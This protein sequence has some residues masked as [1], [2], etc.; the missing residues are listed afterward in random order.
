M[1][2]NVIFWAAIILI[3]FELL[4]IYTLSKSIQSLLKSDFFRKKME[5]S[6]K[7]KE[8]GK[9][10]K[11][12]AGTVATLLVLFAL[13]F[14]SFAQEAAT[15]ATSV[16]EVVEGTASDDTMKYTIYALLS[17]IVLLAGV[18]YYLKSLF[19]N[20]MRIDKTDEEIVVERSEANAKFV[21]VL[22]DAVD[23]EDEASIDLGHEYDGIR[24]LDNNLPPWWK[25][26]FYLTI[27]IGVIYLTH[28]HVLGTGDL[29]EEEYE[30]DMAQAELDIQAY[31][32]EQAM[33]VDENTVTMLLDEGAI[34]NG[35]SLFKNFCVACHGEN[36]EGRVGP[37]LTDEYWINGGSIKDIFKTIKYG[38]NNGMKSWKD[39]LNPVQMQQVASY[40]QS[41]IGTNPP[42]AKD[43]EGDKYTPEEAEE[44]EEKEGD[45]SAEE[46][47]QEESPEDKDQE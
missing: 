13:P 43:P 4:V 7:Q 21:K 40:I 31:L 29:Q 45:T 23:I 25:W 24:E 44:T 36:G 16:V 14:A 12:G 17:I 1:E 33:N 28:Y 3:C 38:A 30:K 10:D 2:T 34:N 6:N 22:T 41:I 42:N 46:N 26:G 39:E 27:F 37:N 15:E 47:A 8:E 18:I 9:S 19:N 5:N 11:N 35:K 32:K 20:L